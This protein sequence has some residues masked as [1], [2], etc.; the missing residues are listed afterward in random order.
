MVR[1]VGRQPGRRGVIMAAYRVKMR[2]FCG[3]C[4]VIETMLALYM[5]EQ[6]FVAPTLNLD[7]IDKRCAMI[8]HA[9]ELVE[10]EVKIASVQNFAFGGVNT[11]LFLKKP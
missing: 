11:C 9:K 2:V 1:G 3:T 10:T 7:E 5:M 4:G 6:G 8:R